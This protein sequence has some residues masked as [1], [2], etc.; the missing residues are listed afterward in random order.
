METIEEKLPGFASAFKRASAKRLTALQWSALDR[1]LV[2]AAF[3]HIASISRRGP[4]KE[5]TPSPKS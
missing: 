4:E 3:E 5:P 1:K 2:M